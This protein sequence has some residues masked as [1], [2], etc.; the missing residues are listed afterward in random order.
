MISI[1]EIYEIVQNLAQKAQHGAITVTEFDK[2]ANMASMDLFNE[3]LGSV[4]DLYKLGKAMSKTG[5]GMNKEIDQSLRPFLVEDLPIA[6]ANN[7]GT[8]PTNC[9]Y[10]D[11]VSFNSKALKWIPKNKVPSYLNNTIDFPTVDYPVYTD[12]STE[13]EVYPSGMNPVLMTYYKTPQT[14]NWGYTLDSG[15]PVYNPLTSIDFEWYPTQKLYLITRILGYIGIT[16]RD[17]ELVQYAEQQEN[18][19]A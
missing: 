8:L 1:N 16:I 18:T 13:I 10:V 9:E 3:K 17:T 19:I 6:V 5:S 2:Y 15:R 11:L 14:V 12:L 4:R 7:K